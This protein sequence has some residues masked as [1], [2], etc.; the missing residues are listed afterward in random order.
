MVK[1]R[2]AAR[3]PRCLSGPSVSF[4]VICIRNV[5]T[6]TFQAG[7]TNPMATTIGHSQPRAYT[8]AIRA[9]S[10]AQIHMQ[11]VIVIPAG[12]PALEPGGGERARQPADAHAPDDDAD[13][14]RRGP[15]MPGQHD[16][17]QDASICSRKFTAAA[18]NALYRRNGCRH[19]QA[20][21]SLSS[22][23]SPRELLPAGAAGAT[24]VAGAAGDA[25]MGAR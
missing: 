1:V 15:V 7:P 3:R 5:W 17:A 2:F 21:P 25:C 14:R 24:A 8:T 19:V 9:S 10:T 16:E 11:P 22:A 18:K 4:G 23:R 6:D 12:Y 20:S 13:L